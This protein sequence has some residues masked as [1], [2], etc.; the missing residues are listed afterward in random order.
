MPGWPWL[1]VSLMSV[2]ASVGGE[3]DVS[4]GEGFAERHD[5]RA[6]VGPFAGEKLTGASEAGGDFVGNQ[7]DVEFVTQAAQLA[8]EVRTVKTHAAGA[9]HN[10]FDGDGGDVVMVLFQKLANGGNVAVVGIDI[11]AH[12]RGGGE[13]MLW[14]HL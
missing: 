11:E 9:L 4:A 14:Q 1:M 6:D 7:Q 2:V 10:R 8:Q 13:E 3:R 5:V 12:L